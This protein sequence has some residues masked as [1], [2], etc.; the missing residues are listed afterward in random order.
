M[1]TLKQLKE[2][3]SGQ[4]VPDW[5]FVDAGLKPAT[6]EAAIEAEPPKRRGRPPKAMNETTEGSEE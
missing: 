3:Y 5:E 6:V 2:K 4:A 1:T